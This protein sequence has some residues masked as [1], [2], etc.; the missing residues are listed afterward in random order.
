MQV[1]RIGEY[2]VSIP[3]DRPV[4]EFNQ[5]RDMP[6]FL[7]HLP[8]DWETIRKLPTIYT[9]R[10]GE[11]WL[12]IGAL[13]HKEEPEGLAE[14]V[15]EQTRVRPE[16]KDVA[17]NGIR[18]KTLGAYADVYSSKAWWLKK[19]SHGIEFRFQGAGNV[20]AET[21]TAVDA[22][23]NSVAHVGYVA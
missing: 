10:F 1:L 20:S 19:G 22:I 21:R 6:D 16:L 3:D 7:R 8:F 23:L 18:G 2:T 9:V 4:E 15:F 12:S 11:Q 14:M 13:P 5:Y 17:I